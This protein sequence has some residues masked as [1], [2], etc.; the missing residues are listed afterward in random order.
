[1]ISLGKMQ[2]IF[3]KTIGGRKATSSDSPT[4]IALLVINLNF[5]SGERKGVC[6]SN[7]AKVLSV[8]YFLKCFLEDGF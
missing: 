8:L 1:M 7:E 5:L 4:V 3:I 6:T 2:R